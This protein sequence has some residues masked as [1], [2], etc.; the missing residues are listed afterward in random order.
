MRLGVVA[1]E[2]KSGATRFVWYASAMGIE[3]LR[4]EVITSGARYKDLLEDDQWF[5]DCEVAEIAK[6]RGIVLV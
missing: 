1:P 4:A 3:E 5:V 2:R 6:E